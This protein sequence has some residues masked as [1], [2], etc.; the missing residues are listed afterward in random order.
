MKNI[1]KLEIGK[2]YKIWTADYNSKTKVWIDSIFTNPVTPEE[3]NSK[4]IVYRIWIKRKRYFKWFACPYFSLAIW[5][6]WE[7]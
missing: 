1:K 6:N 2:S 5:N 7:Y 4:I 3:E